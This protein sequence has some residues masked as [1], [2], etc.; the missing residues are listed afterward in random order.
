MARILET[1]D[2]EP[3]DKRPNGA[4]RRTWEETGDRQASRSARDS[5]KLDGSSH[6]RQR[7][8]ARP[9]SASPPQALRECRVTDPSER[10]RKEVYFRGRVQGVGFRY[11]TAR[12]A[13]RFDVRGFVENLPDGR[14]LLVAE[15]PREEVERFVEAV[16]HRMDRYIANMH[17]TES[18]PTD[19][20]DDFHI[21]Y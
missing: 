5:G 7:P 11:T 4:V 21:R 10:I 3:D 18:P 19:E 1:C 9:G 15:G 13:Q 16:A 2:A 8:A 12:V 14:V 17:A 20:F 6:T